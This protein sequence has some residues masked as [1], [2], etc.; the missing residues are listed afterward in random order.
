MLCWFVARSAVAPRLATKGGTL[1]VENSTFQF[2]SVF[3]FQQD[4]ERFSSSGHQPELPTGKTPP[5]VQIFAG[6][7]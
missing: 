1:E 5:S 7:Y 6:S 4:S 2:N 3:L